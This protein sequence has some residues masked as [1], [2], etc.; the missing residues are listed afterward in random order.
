LK[1]SPTCVAFL[2]ALGPRDER[3]GELLD[4][5]DERILDKAMIAP[6]LRSAA[7]ASASRPTFSMEKQRGERSLRD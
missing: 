5:T 3:L 6:N 4:S 2:A 1:P 7:K